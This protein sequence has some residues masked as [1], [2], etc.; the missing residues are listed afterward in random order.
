MP[1]SGEKLGKITGKRANSDMTAAEH[2][3]A[4]IKAVLR[5]A[6]P[7]SLRRV[8]G[9]GN[10]VG[11]RYR[12]PA[13]APLFIIAVVPTALFIRVSR[14]SLYLVQEGPTGIYKFYG[15]IPWDAFERIYPDGLTKIRKGT[16]VEA[17]VSFGIVVIALVFAAFVA[18][19]L[20]MLL[21]HR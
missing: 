15:R 14:G 16:G 3:I 9:F 18:S 6:S 10:L 13:I 8:N 17:I 12:D 7:A 2:R 11:G 1:A 5:K 20:R 21:W 19:G 4:A